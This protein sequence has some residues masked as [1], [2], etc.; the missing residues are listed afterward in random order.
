LRYQKNR[1]N[2]SSRFGWRAS[3]PQLAE[4]DG[5][6]V[7]A[8]IPPMRKQSLAGLLAVV[9]TSTF[10][11]PGL[12]DDSEGWQFEFTPYLIM[13]GLEGQAGTQVGP[14][15]IVADVDASFSDILENLEA[16]FM[17]IFTA[18]KGP[19][20][21]G[22]DGIYMN[23]ETNSAVGESAPIVSRRLTVDSTMTIWQGLVGYRVFDQET[24]IDLVGAVRYVDLDLGLE[25]AA[26]EPPLIG[27]GT[28]NVSGSESWTDLVV[29][30]KALHPVSENISLMGYVDIGAGGSDLTYQVVGGLNWELSD[31]FVAKAGYR[32]MYWDYEDDGTVWDIAAS[33]PYLG[34]GIRF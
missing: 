27:P 33:G 12:A 11:T 29:G 18:R 24:E 2:L 6:I 17:G 10:A 15:P 16:G 3:D 26:T 21:F 1:V 19:W 32:Y 9:L 4:N 34:L 28:R 22:L 13:A 14:V 7:R 8:R 30:A 25:V 5:S 31:T 20:T 23:L